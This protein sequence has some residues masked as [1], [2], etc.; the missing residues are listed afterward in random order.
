MSVA[1]SVGFD[2][3]DELFA[4]TLRS[5]AVDQL[6]PS[7]RRWTSE[8]YPRERLRELAR[9][10]VTGLRVPA[11]YGGSAGTH[12]QLGIAGEEL[13]RGDFN[14]SNFVQ[15]GAIG[16]ELLLLAD[17]PLRAEW[18]PRLA[19]GDAVLSFGLTEPGVG[20]DAA[21]LVT[22]ARRDRDAWVLNGEKASI[23]F[24]GL[25][26]ACIVF[27]R[28]GGPGAR[29]ISM[30]FVPLDT[31]GVSRHVYDGVGG[32][33]TQRGSLFFDD[34]R[35]P[36]EHQI[37]TEGTGFVAAMRS[38]DFN[39][40]LIALSAIGA[41]Q[42]SLDETVIYAKERHTFGKSLARHE[43][44]AFQIAEHTAKLHATRLLGYQVMA[45][46]DAGRPHTMEAA[47]VKWLG[48]MQATDAI[49]ACLLLHG[50]TGYGNDLPFGQRLTDVIGLEIGDGTP[51]IMK[52]IVARELFGR[53]HAAYK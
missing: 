50:W 25:A 52:A 49:H 48:P 28:T 2:E 20:S 45:L 6:L 37:G 9:L 27:A 40:A 38:F 17:E 14:I 12:V 11:E 41:A 8:A 1:S 32:A 44:V 26:D 51:E 5:Y 23:T 30:L 13:S 35:V 18:L 22:T 4:R 34:V 53:D 7:Y 33:L 39:R 16:A 43:G 47:M 46:A 24:A 3:T 21:N 29:G 15:L 42:Q 31:P 36:V 10:G 19:S